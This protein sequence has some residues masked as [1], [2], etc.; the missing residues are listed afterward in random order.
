MSVF[1]LVMS[2][3]AAF[4]QNGFLVWVYPSLDCPFQKKFY[5][6][7]EEVPKKMSVFYLVMSLWAAFPQNGFLVWVYPNVAVTP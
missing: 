5:L 4:P 6:F 2:L 1:Y 3:W 7:I